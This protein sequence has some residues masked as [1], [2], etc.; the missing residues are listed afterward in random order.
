[1]SG[2]RAYLLLHLR[3]YGRHVKR[4]VD[5]RVDIVEYLH[6]QQVLI[7]EGGHYRRRDN[8][9][10]SQGL[11]FESPLQFHCAFGVIL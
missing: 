1:M 2:N 8:D 6:A 7:V 4:A 11:Q 10:A 5:S 3:G 9:R